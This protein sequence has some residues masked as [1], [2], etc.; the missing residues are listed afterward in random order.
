MKENKMFR[1]VVNEIYTTDIQSVI[2]S[3]LNKSQENIKICVA[4]INFKVFEEIL[5]GKIV[6][7]VKVEII[8]DFNESNINI[9]KSSRL[10]NYI[11]I[12]F[13]KNPIP[14]RLMHNKFCIIDDS[15][16][17]N[18]SYNWSTSASYHYENIVITRYDYPLIRHF[19]HVFADLE[20][21]G[22]MS[23]EKFN[24]NAINES[25]NTFN[26]GTYGSP[27]GI[28]GISDLNIWCANLTENTA[29]RIASMQMPNFYD[30]LDYDVDYTSYHD[31]K[32]YEKD[33]F[34]Q[35]RMQMREL[36]Q[37]F[38]NTELPVHAIGTAAIANSH[39]VIE[40][41]EPEVKIISLTWI[42]MRYKNILPASF[43][44]EG[45]FARIWMELYFSN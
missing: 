7:G 2:L 41:G 14:D 29:T 31:K 43:A 21:M 26:L 4:W 36:Q 24:S 28:L 8:C 44:A 45:D 22:A 15:I 40:Y 6:S 19:K 11:S 9:W 20:Y 3:E 12:T 32:E 35:E 16:S 33:L 1:Q 42:D 38:S 18:G 37:F 17:I 10:K 13:I 30:I 34:I 27:S 5:I 39:E 25:T 23:P